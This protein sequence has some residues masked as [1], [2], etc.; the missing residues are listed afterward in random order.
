MDVSVP[1]GLK[2]L[3]SYGPHPDHATELMLFGQFVGSWDLEVTWYENGALVR[4]ARGEWHFF[5]ALE[6]RGVQD[7][8][9]VP[10]RAERPDDGA[11]CYEYGATVRFFDPTIAAWRSTWHGPMRHAV[12]Q[13]TAK[14]VGD[15][16]VLAGRHADERPL[17]WTLSDIRADAFR[18]RSEVSSGTDDRW[19]L[20][21]E[22]AA[23]RSPTA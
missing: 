23:R 18:W 7:V 21:Q 19:E 20:L 22:F 16:I 10:P 3:L 9:I 12:I 11:G 5:W 17:R 2:A 13:F 1:E 8:W 4:R 15:E 6:G 14:R